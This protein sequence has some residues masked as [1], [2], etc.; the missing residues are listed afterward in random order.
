[1]NKSPKIV[2]TVKK[3][4]HGAN[5]AVVKSVHL[6][7]ESGDQMTA[8]TRLH[9]HN[10]YELTVI[11]RADSGLHF[12]NDT[13]TAFRT[14]TVFL[15]RPGEK[16]YHEYSGQLSIINFMFDPPTM[17][18]YHRQWSQLPA[19]SVVFNP[20]PAQ[21]EFH[22]SPSVLAELEIF[23]NTI[24][25]ESLRKLP[26]Y[27]LVM[28]NN[29]INAIILILRQHSQPNIMSDSSISA[30]ISYMAAHFNKPL[31]IGQL[32]KVA[33]LSRSVLFRKFQREFGISPVR[34]LN[35]YRIDRAKEYLLRSDMTIAE[36]AAATGF[37]DP[38]YFSRQF[39]R[40]AGV[41][42]RKYRQEDHGARQEI[43]GNT[44]TTIR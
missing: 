39:T 32:T 13:V 43:K 25:S 26:G 4:F 35:N 40:E 20:D 24:S 37:A 44:T 27:Q 12:L 19:Y 38:L 22:V 7:P 36:V 10:F 15:V 21:R 29:L 9:S 17:Q 16:H 30:V 18:K 3:Y 11:T 14:G 8:A 34:W 6:P 42:P 33:N 5:V 1:M 23:F 41:S 28:N 2:N 31:N